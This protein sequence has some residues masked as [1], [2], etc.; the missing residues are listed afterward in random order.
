MNVTVKFASLFLVFSIWSS[1]IF[2]QD[3]KLP[4]GLKLNA[5]VEGITEYELENGLKVLLFPDQSKPQVTVNVTYL[6]GSRHEDY[7]ETGMAHLLEH[8]VFKGTP[9]RPDIAKE[10]KDHGAYF[11]GTTYYDRTNYFETVT[12]TDENLEWALAMEA[13]RMVN[14]NIAKKD[15]DSEMTVVRNEFEIGE[16]NPSNILMQRV[17]ST[18]Y[19]WHNYGQSTIGARADLENVP[20]KRLQA[21]YKE[22]YQPDNAVLMVSGKFETEKTLNWIVEFFGPIPRPERAI[23][24]TYTREPVQDG[25]RSVTLRRS[26]DVQVVSAAYHIC[27]ASH[28]DYPALAVLDAILS[29]EPAGRLYKEVVETKKASS[30]WSYSPGFKEPGFMYISADVL[31]DKPLE[32]AKDAIVNALDN[33]KDNPVTQEE[34]DRAKTTLI[35]D[36]ELSFNDSR[37]VGVFMS[38][39][40]AAGDWRLIFLFRD[41]LEEVTVEDVNRVAKNYLKPSN[42]TMGYFYPE[43]NP[44]RTEVPE[45]VDVESLVANY[46]GR[47][48]IAQGEAFDPS[49][50]NIENRVKRVMNEDGLDIAL[51][52]KENRGDAVVARMNFRFGDLE[53]LK[54]TSYVSGLTASMLNKGTTS[55]SRQEIQDEFDRLKARVNIGGNSA[56]VSVSIETERASLPEVIKLVS[57]IMQSP[58]FPEEE[59]AKLKD[60]QLAQIESQ[61]SDPM[62]KTQNAFFRT[63]NPLPKDHPNY[64]STFDEEVEGIKNTSV[65]DLKA[66]Y[67]KF[68]GASDATITVVGDFDEGEIQQ[69]VEEEFGDWKSPMKFQR[70]ASEVHEIKP[71]NKKIETPDKAN[72]AFFA[73]FAFPMN[74]GHPDYAA[75]LMANYMLGGGGLSSRLA[76]RIRKKDG[77]SYA[78]GSFLSAHPKDEKA[79]FI[80]YAMYAP[81]NL[82]KLEAAF[83]EE[84]QK[85]LNEGF[86]EEEFAAAKKGWLESRTVSRSQDGGLASKLNSHLYFGRD[87][88]WDAAIEDKIGK[89]TL[90]EVNAAVKKHIRPEKFVVIKAGDF[91]GAAK[92]AEEKANSTVA[93]PEDIA[94]EEIISRYVAESGGKEKLATVA[95]MKMVSNATVQGMAIVSTQYHK[96]P[97]KILMEISAGGNIMQKI[98]FDGEVGSIEA[99]GQGQPMPAD[100]KEEMKTTHIFPELYYGETGVSSKLTG[101]ETVN[102]EEAYVLEVTKASGKVTTE[103]F[104]VASGL[105]VRAIEAQ[106]GGPKQ[107]TDYGDYKE[108]GGIMMPHKITITGAMPMPLEM[109]VETIEFNLDLSDDLFVVKKP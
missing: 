97:N 100:M 5:S 95:S 49:P 54:N 42:R 34:V 58:S 68:Y 81:E 69:L 47:E 33:I 93:V 101:I 85:A 76:D 106:S 4:E 13:D 62:A 1:A 109:I 87:M 38:E 86:E 88:S 14:S 61:R 12:A 23:M 91:E 71:E 78:V 30:L 89:L 16:N 92:K 82:E 63:L 36:W 48:E 51:L 44:D 25:E 64:M 2:S 46:K 60:E 43:K 17:L 31:Q 22:Y 103:Y 52:S 104:S 53:S 107:T 96:E 3:V 39:R 26:G 99:M 7:G 56:V 29:E 11:N 65:D 59:L 37:Q 41:Y 98:I 80:T 83:N 74:D 108:V 102:D 15:L 55:K 8:L 21:F 50:T 84:I 70:I 72:A 79:Q 75:T 57:E 73:G 6:V 45:A 66:F 27:A 90:E 9:T 35:K 10:L 77:L 32:E 105:K 20:I 19:L 24:N 40:I 28:P 94:P 18:S 67:N